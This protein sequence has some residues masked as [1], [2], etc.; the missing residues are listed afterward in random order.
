VGLGRFYPEGARSLVEGAGAVDQS[1]LPVG[2]LIKHYRRRSGNR[3]QAAVAGLC[4]ISERYLQ[5]IEAGQK[6]PSAAVLARIAAELGVPV[7]ALLSEEPSKGHPR[8]SL[9]RQLW[10]V[11]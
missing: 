5:Q 6:V 10:R 11:L 8:L 1:R 9:Q 3:S 4:G 7:A 2:A